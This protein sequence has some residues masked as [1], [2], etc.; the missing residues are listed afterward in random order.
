MFSISFDIA[1]SALHAYTRHTASSVIASR[2]KK[3]H[4]HN[5]RHAHKFVL[6]PVRC[7]PI[8][9]IN[10]FVCFICLHIKQITCVLQKS[11]N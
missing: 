2:Y 5:V 1:R 11:A 3:R 4:R 7:A 6:R 9:S 10:L 8:Y